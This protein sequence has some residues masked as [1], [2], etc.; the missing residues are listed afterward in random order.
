LPSKWSAYDPPP[1]K[2]GNDTSWAALPSG[3]SIGV[4][5]GVHAILLVGADVCIGGDFV[6]LGDGTSANNVAKWST[7]SQTWSLF[8]AGSS[9]GVN[10]GVRGMGVV[11]T[12][13]YM[14]HYRRQWYFG[15]LYCPLVHHVE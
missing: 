3:L 6:I 11:G 10:S 12:D 13:V 8:L 1:L 2:T 9:N 15:Y 4:S 7:A 14:V 5:K